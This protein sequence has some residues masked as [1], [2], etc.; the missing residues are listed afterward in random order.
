MK[1]SME[2]VRAN[3]LRWRKEH[4]LSPKPQVI[5]PPRIKPPERIIKLSQN[6]IILDIDPATGE[7]MVPE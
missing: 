3:V 4:G 7:V 2:T 5:N 6:S 1:V